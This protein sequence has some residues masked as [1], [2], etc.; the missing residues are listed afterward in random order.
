MV[1]ENDGTSERV[2]KPGGR[3][4]GMCDENER[5]IIDAIGSDSMVL[6]EIGK[7]SGLGFEGALTAMEG[8]M[9]KGIVKNLGA[10]RFAL[11]I[12]NLE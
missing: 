12:F 2:P 11:E 4:L 7:A 8:L 1:K 6:E 5:R 9:Q 3:D 10:G